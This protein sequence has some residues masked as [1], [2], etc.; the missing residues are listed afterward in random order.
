[1]RRVC[2]CHSRLLPCTLNQRLSAAD[3]HRRS[4]FSTPFPAVD[5]PMID[6]RLST[7]EKMFVFCSTSDIC[8]FQCTLGLARNVSSITRMWHPWLRGSLGGSSARLHDEAWQV[9][10]PCERRDPC[11]GPP[12]AASASDALGAL[13][14]PAGDVAGANKFRA[15]ASAIIGNAGQAHRC[16][17]RLRANMRC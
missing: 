17:A 16:R 6:Y 12:P 8:C 11:E 10:G 3:F 2:I 14:V 13:A 4:L 9:S 7:I 15:A 5:Y 1:M